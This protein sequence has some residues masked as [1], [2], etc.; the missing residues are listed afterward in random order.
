MI[1]RTRRM[2]VQIVL[3]ETN[4]IH[5]WIVPS[6]ERLQT[7]RIIDSGASCAHVDIAKAR[8]RLARQSHTT[9]PVPFI[10]IGRAL[11]L[12]RLQREGHEEIPQQLTG[13]LVIT[14]QR[15]QRIIGS[16]IVIQAIFHVPK[17]LAG[18]LAT[19]PALV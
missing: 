16:G 18:D 12:T 1:Q 17:I 9:G 6:D 3:D 19:T 5:S 14:A 8:L 10:C 7:L 4:L 11:R 13:S 15:E 2:R